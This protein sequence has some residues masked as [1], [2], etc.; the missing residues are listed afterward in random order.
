MTLSLAVPIAA[1]IG[2]VLVIVAVSYQQTI[3]A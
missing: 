2:T 1:A 3:H